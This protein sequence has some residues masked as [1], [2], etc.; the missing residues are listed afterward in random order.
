MGVCV[1]GCVGEP[2]RQKRNKKKLFA[3][4]RICSCLPWFWYVFSLD[5]FLSHT[6]EYDMYR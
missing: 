5:R 6:M 1:C 2:K 4:N 3:D